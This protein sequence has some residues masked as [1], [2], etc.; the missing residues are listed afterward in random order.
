MIYVHPE[1]KFVDGWEGEI[2]KLVKIQLENDFWKKEDIMLVTNFPYE[3]NGVKAIE[4]G[5][6][7]YCAYKPTVSKIYVL[8]DL[9]NRGI[10]KDELYW[11]HDF[12]AFQLEPFEG[13]PI[14]GFD[15][16][17][18]D[19][20]IIG[21]DRAYNLR[22]S[23]GTIFFNNKTKDIFEEWKKENDRYLTNEEVSLLAMSHKGRYKPLFDRITKLNITY[24]FAIRRRNIQLTYEICDKPIKVIHFHP[25]DRRTVFYINPRVNNIEAIIEGKNPLGV[26]ITNKLLELFKKHKIYDK[27]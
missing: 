26:L 19:Y 3:Y 12:D 5:D 8:I 15:M 24:N 10:I 11:F 9:F 14:E 22:P 18:T 16:G 20:G 27:D 13:N 25:W 23:T 17:M 1:H 21:I 7:C 6:E 4:V 2:E